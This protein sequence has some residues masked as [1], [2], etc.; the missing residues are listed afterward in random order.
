MKEIFSGFYNRLKKNPEDTFIFSS[1]T[2]LSFVEFLKLSEKIEKQ[3]EPKSFVPIII[4]NKIQ[5]LLLIFN[6]WSNKSAAVPLSVRLN[7]NEILNIVRYHKFKRILIDEEIFEN[8]SAIRKEIQLKRIKK[9]LPPLEEKD[10]LENSIERLTISQK[11][12][13]SLIMHT[14]GSEG[15]PKGAVHSFE[16]LSHSAN[17]S[18]SFIQSSYEDRWLLSLPIYHIGGFMIFYRALVHGNQIVIPDSLSTESLIKAIDRFKPTLISLTPTQLKR[19]FDANY[20][21]PSSVRIIFIGGGPSSNELIKKAL[22]NKYP[23]AKVYGST[24]TSSMIT[25][26]NEDILKLNPASS[27]IPLPGVNLKINKF[28]NS[29]E[30]DILVK[31]PS[32]FLNYLNM[33]I[34]TKM[35]FEKGYYKTGDIGEI[36]AVGSLIVLSRRSDLIISGGENIS[37]YEVESAIKTHPLVADAF[38]FSFEDY[39]WGQIVCAAVELKFKEALQEEQLKSYLKK[40]ISSFKI[41][42]RFYFIDKIPKNEIGKI[43]KKELFKILNLDS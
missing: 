7:A 31:S 21:V 24:E 14:S 2:K 29:N 38:V 13:I 28:P 20:V 4:D 42:K 15:T 26:A 1:T 36:D 39:E 32:L 37:T 16:T 3:I 34:E 8:Y 23:I 11:E 30:G 43:E 25:V 22:N 41:P 19:M 40:K 33:P 27:G 17:M 5:S 18:N 9:I 10:F 12:N 35:S 6:I